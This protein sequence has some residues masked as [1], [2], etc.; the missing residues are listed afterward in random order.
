MSDKLKGTMD[1]YMSMQMVTEAKLD[2]VN[3]KELDKKF[4]DRED[5]D[6][7]NDGDTDSSDEFLHKRR[8]AIDNAVDAKKKTKSEA[9][10]KKEDDEEE[11]DEEEDDEVEEIKV[12]ANY[13]QMMAKKKKKAGKEE[14]EPTTLVKKPSKGKNMN[15]TDTKAEIS[16]I[17]EMSTRE[18][19]YE[20]WAQIHEASDSGRKKSATAPE[21][22]LGNESPKSKEFAKMHDVEDGKKPELVADDEEGHE[23]SG[24]A[25]R[26]TK[27][28]AARPGDNAQGDKAV[29][30]STKAEQYVAFMRKWQKL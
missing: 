18:A 17:A 4:K 14:G 29:V 12:P 1:A 22:A 19:F 10:K 25:E 11:D 9:F 5:K 15:T 6:I 20:L 28:A 27:K 30:Q 26:L 7:D 8:A 16:K 2:P 23:L 21:T 3:N 13:A 24:K